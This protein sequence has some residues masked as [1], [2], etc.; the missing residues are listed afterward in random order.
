MILA[1]RRAFFI[2]LLFSPRTVLGHSPIEGI[3]EFYNGLL[4]PLFV[5]AHLLSL[6]ALGLLFGQQDEGQIQ[7]AI[8]AFVASAALGL[9]ASGFSESLNIEAILLV[10]AALIGLLIAI[11]PRIPGFFL[12]LIGIFTGLAVGLDSNQVGLTGKA[13]LVALFGSGISIYFLI[14]YPMGL[15][16]SFSKKP[17]QRIGVRVIGSWFAASAL[18]VLS[19]LFS[20]EIR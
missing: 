17:W 7:K 5:P 14:L 1:L 8:I 12:S 6:L 10:N 11:N 13:R 3:N 9:L 2:A 20:N 15:A 16:E 18:L 4:H 19:L